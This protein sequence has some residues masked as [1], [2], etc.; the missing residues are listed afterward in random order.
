MAE[1]LNFNIHLI[2]DCLVL[3]K[4]SKPT[5][6]MIFEI[7]NCMANFYPR[8]LS[9]DVSTKMREKAEQGYYPSHA[10]CGYKNI[11]IYRG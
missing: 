6:Y 3:N 10:P 11:R 2:Q 7:S 5:D 9:I 8:N 1:Y 4:Q